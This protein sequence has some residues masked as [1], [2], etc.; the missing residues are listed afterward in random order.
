VIRHLL[1]LVWNRK[2]SNALLTLEI[3]FSFL[4]VF[5]VATALSFAAMAYRR[6]LGFVWQDVWAVSADDQGSGARMPRADEA[7]VD[8]RIAIIDRLLA[9]ARSLPEVEAAASLHIAPFANGSMTSGWTENG[10]EVSSEIAGAT[11]DLDK[12]LGLRVVDGR[13]FEPA[14][15]AQPWHAV[16]INRSLERTLGGGESMVGKPLR[17]PAE[18]EVEDRVI[19]VVEDFRRSGE[20]APPGNIFIRLVRAGNSHDVPGGNLLLKLR[21]GTRA[22][23]EETLIRRLQAIAPEWSFEAKPLEQMR[24]AALRTRLAPFAIGAVVAGFLMLMVALGLFGVLWQNLVRRTREI[25]LRRATGASA[26]DVRK[27]VL[28][29]QLLLASLAM[30][31][32]LALVLQLPLFGLTALVG[33][34]AFGLGIATS[35]IVIL[36]LTT[37]CS[38]YP[39]VLVARLDPADALRYE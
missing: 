30:A 14:D 27:Q 9:E 28:F 3:F 25:G 5:A 15:A 35:V 26:A 4:V 11:Q 36:T 19:G 29:E 34:T 31:L 2:R 22:A 16:V 32:G 20:I 8:P 37:L 23:F 33:P 1:R 6:P 38:L 18:G 17:T 7:A 10:R 13:W 39:A 12:V 24:A 21:P